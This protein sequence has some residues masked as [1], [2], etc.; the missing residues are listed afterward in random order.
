M[1][2]KD[3]KERANKCAES[4]IYTIFPN[5]IKKGNEIEIG[6]L[7]GE[8]GR[9]CKYNLQ[10][11]LWSDFASPDKGGD[12]ISLIKE[13]KGLPW[14]E[15]QLG[16]AP[17][18]DFIFITPAP[19][20]DMSRVIHPTLGKP[21]LYHP[22]RDKDGNL[23]NYV[24]RFAAE[25]NKIWPYSFTDKGWRW[26]QLPSPRPLYNLVMLNK[27][28]DKTIIIVEGEKCADALQAKLPENPVITW[29]GGA[30]GVNSA[31]FSPLYGKENIIIWPDHDEPGI[32][33]ASRIEK[34]L[35]KNGCKD[36]NI[37][38][39]PDDKPKGWD[40]A[41]AILEEMDIEEFIKQALIKP[42]VRP[43]KWYKPLGH[44]HGLYY[45]YSNK[46]KQVVELSPEKHNESNMYMLANPQYWQSLGFFGTK[47]DVDYKLVMRFLMDQCH[48]VGVYAPKNVRGRGACIDEG[49]L[50]YHLGNK[51]IVD[52]QERQLLLES[53]TNIYEA[54][55]PI[56]LP[57][58]DNPLTVTEAK[59]FLDLSRYLLWE[60]TL[61][62]YYLAGWCVLA[63][64]SGA[65]RWRPHIWITAPMG[66]GKTT[67]VESIISE[68]LIKKNFCLF[69]S[70]NSTSAGISARLV[71]EPLPV[72]FDESEADTQAGQARIQDV[73][74]MMRVASSNNGAEVL[75]GSPQQRAHNVEVRSS[76]CLASI[77]VAI[78][79]AA[80]ESRCCVLNLKS[81]NWGDKDEEQF[82]LRH[83][84]EFLNMKKFMNR[85]YSLRFIARTLRMW[86]IL[87]DNIEIFR[88]AAAAE[89]GNNRAGD[90][91]G[92]LLAGAYSLISDDRIGMN[93]ARAWI[94][95][96]NVKRGFV[97]NKVAS[98][99][100]L[101]M[102]Y[103][104]TLMIVGG[105]RVHERT[106]KELIDI[107][108]GVNKDMR[109]SYEEASDK[110][111][112]T[113]MAVLDGCLYIANKNEMLAQLLRST[114][115]VD[116]WAHVLKQ[117]PNADNNDNRGVN[118]KGVVSKCTRIK[119]N[120]EGNPFL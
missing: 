62:A 61:S 81:P 20:L 15:Q 77:G 83:Y 27:L 68:L 97:E 107:A 44:N 96:Q 40:C 115:Y 64:L 71:A 89:L 116:T 24:F 106:V 41:D 42:D 66:T 18:K 54:L 90:Q 108:S 119:L 105:D 16:E 120:G 70:G 79:H 113:G 86:P 13:T 26:K 8:L 69:I 30:N 37:L 91:I 63:P 34:I 84:A 14:L 46:T 39:I 92:S 25:G 21:I 94:S 4:L 19:E 87:R 67:I 1:D 117:M 23:L 55:D 12:I 47:K 98:T 11:N 9:S 58:M 103:T 114:P 111:A 99:G 118:F 73:L 31:D 100:C 10:K 109:V 72:I 17:K 5:A 36:I 110:L 2:I 43:E 6:S 93:E 48:E 3:L 95:E 78:K 85:E 50:V 28:K 104:K 51:L 74:S 7:N 75:K 60:N 76:F 112:R 65:L 80:D 102:L 45:Y 88:S 22:Y 33:A 35:S 38:N 82:R 56:A 49:R 57:Y 32:S 53:S 29:S 59:K 52:G 101:E